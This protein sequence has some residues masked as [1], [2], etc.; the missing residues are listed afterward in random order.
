MVKDNREFMKTISLYL[1]ARRMA[2]K[3][4]EVD[5]TA[6]KEQLKKAYRRAAIKF[7]PDK[8]PDTPRANKKFT[9]VKCAYKLL[10]ED[11]PC[12]E[13]LKGINS[14]SDV[15]E[16]SKYNLSNP[17]GYFLWWREIFFDSE[18]TKEKS[19]SKRSSCI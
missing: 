16:G 2:C 15:P 1:E 17:W 4:L 8:N 13:L 5:E 10:A 7:H 19:N 12:P 3:I 18:K 11:K 6:D 9:L 14:W